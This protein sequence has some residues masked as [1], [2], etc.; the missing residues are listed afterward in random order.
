MTHL[1]IYNFLMEGMQTIKEFQK[2]E[3]THVLVPVDNLHKK[4]HEKRMHPLRVAYGR[5]ASDEH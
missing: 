5:F 2:Q 1:F 3:E 4:K